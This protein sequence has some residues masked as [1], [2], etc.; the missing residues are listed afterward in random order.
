MKKDSEEIARKASQDMY[1]YLY[2]LLPAYPSCGELKQKA[3][4][5][6]QA[7][8]EEEKKNNKEYDRITEH[9]RLQAVQEP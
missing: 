5:L 9:G 6:A 4:A 3:D 1:D 2:V 8:L 7:V